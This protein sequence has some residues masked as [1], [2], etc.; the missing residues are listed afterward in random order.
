MD[1]FFIVDK[2]PGMTS[3]DVVERLRRLLRPWGRPK[4][5]H[6]GTLDPEATGVLPI[7]V[8]RA[9]RLLD[10]LHLLPKRYTAEWIGGAATD[11]EDWTGR[12]I[13]EK[14][15]VGLDP[16]AVR[17]AFRRFVGTYDQTPPMVSAVKVGGVPLYERARRGETVARSPRRVVIEALEI[18]AMDL[19]R[20]DPRVVFDL[21]ASSGTY[22]RTLCV[23]VGRALGLPA[24]MGWLVRTESGG[25][26][27]S[28][29]RTLE[30][31][32]AAS[33]CG[34]LE[35]HLVPM[36]HALSFLPSVVVAREERD[37]VRTGS[38]LPPPSDPA[39]RALAPGSRVAVR[40]EGGRLL[41]VYRVADAGKRRGEAWA[42][43]ERV[44]V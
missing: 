22:V 39:L 32:E 1:G 11:T 29:A 17:A 20:P 40:D 36:E 41:A 35:R 37:R 27:L 21:R 7:G 10:Y 12:V 9:T 43:A 15:A 19:D 4:V 38:A 42:V 8:G 26:S 2:P 30:E 33:N 3:H 18:L 6:G 34:T 44:L 23:D 25:F 5:G 24:H 14:A 31:L 13:E 16:A 28:E